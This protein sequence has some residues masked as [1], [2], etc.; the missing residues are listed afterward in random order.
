MRRPGE[1]S[2]LPARNHPETA[3]SHVRGAFWR[4]LPKT[5]V[6]AAQ[7][8]RAMSKI[9][10]VT[11]AAL[12]AFSGALGQQASAEPVSGL[13]GEQAATAVWAADNE[14]GP[15]RAERSVQDGLGDWIVWVRD[16]DNDLWLCNASAEGNVYA[17][18]LIRGDRLEGRGEEAIALMPVALTSHALPEADKAERICAVAGRKVGAANI[19]TTVED[20]LGDYVVWLKGDGE[21]SWLCNASAKAQLYVFEPIRAPIHGSPSGAGF[22]GA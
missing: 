1:T 8:E 21:T 9:R 15:A 17:N 12:F 5:A 22:L 6:D 14:F 3:G 2:F 16:K 4:R 11:A 18:T 19:I 10:M 20:G 13:T 7:M